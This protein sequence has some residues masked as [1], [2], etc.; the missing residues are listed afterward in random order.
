ML[1]VSRRILSV[2]S[3]ALVVVA[4]VAQVGCGV[5]HCVEREAVAAADAVPPCHGGGDARDAGSSHAPGEGNGS[6]CVVMP[7]E[8]AAPAPSISFHASY[9][10]LAPDFRVVVA[11]GWTTR[12][13]IPA[14]TGP[15]RTR[16]LAASL[17]LRI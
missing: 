4:T 17:P 15:P 16:R 1:D 5:V 12:A 11:S 9:V 8:Q 2:A 3:V 14:E 7:L 10:A 6:C 13:S